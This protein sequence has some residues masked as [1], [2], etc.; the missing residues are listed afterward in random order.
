MHAVIPPKKN[1]TIQR[2]YDEALYKLR[3]LVEN[4]F[5]MLKRWRGIATRY[6]KNGRSFLAAVHIRC[7]ALWLNIS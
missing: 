1:R 7:L 2:P 6:A 3:H 5:L 4:A